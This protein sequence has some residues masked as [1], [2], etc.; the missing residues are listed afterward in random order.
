LF[1][2]LSLGLKAQKEGVET[3]GNN[4]Q[5][6]YSNLDSWWSRTVKESRLI[7]GQE[8]T[9]FEPGPSAAEYQN[10]EGTLD[11]LTPWATSNVRAEV[12]VAAANQSV[13]REPRG[14]GYCARLE[15]NLKKVVVLGVVNVK[16][17]A[18]GSMF[19]GTM[20]DPITD[21]NNPR[22]NTFMGI[23]FT[24]APVAL[25]FDYKVQLGQKRQNAT[26]GFRV[27]DI[28]GP[29]EAEVYMIL[30]NRTEDE[31]GNLKVKRIGT[32]W[33]RFKQN[34]DTWVN[35]HQ[36]PVIYGDA[37]NHRD[38]Q[39]FMNLISEAD[40]Y[41]AKNSQGKR[42]SYIEEAWCDDTSQ[43]THAIIVFS[44]SYE[45]GAYIGSP[46]SR[47]WVDNIQLIYD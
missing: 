14:H 5:I 40:P 10:I 24:H 42:V 15:T 37:T 16:A 32:A 25:A 19:L 36:V 45:G 7:G 22:H 47:L 27:K 33:Q 31:H 11:G 34:Q 20:E 38:Y 4:E 29:D 1:L 17:I 8:I 28:D 23:P 9:Y 21:P 26:G 2:F 18:S 3:A 46:D 44:A 12:G 39:P 35:G 6:K 30:Q 43:I 41:Y 13:Y